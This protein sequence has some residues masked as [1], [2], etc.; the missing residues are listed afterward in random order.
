MSLYCI[1]LLTIKMD[2]EH[3]RRRLLGQYWD[4]ASTFE[5]PGTL[6]ELRIKKFIATLAFEDMCYRLYAYQEKV[7]Q[8]VNAALLLGYSQ[9]DRDLRE[10]VRSAL[11][12]RGEQSIL[13]QL[14]LLSKEPRIKTFIRRRH[15]FAHRLAEHQL[16]ALSG[17]R[18][19]VDDQYDED[20][21]EAQ[22]DRD[23]W[24]LLSESMDVDA[25]RD[26]LVRE[27]DDVMETL[28]RFE[29]ELCRKLMGG[30][31]RRELLRA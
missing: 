2:V 8:F 10:K 15:E 19:L 27:F 16:R 23:R 9:E 6:E 20:D 1:E 14:D 4:V 22:L 25:Y 24:D 29:P 28:D 30:L 12:A 5:E 26:S 18:R 13:N 31:S 7:F 21:I 3:I 11:Q 17:L